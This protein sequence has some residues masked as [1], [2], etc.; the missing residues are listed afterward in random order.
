MRKET[1]KMT[2]TMFQRNSKNLSIMPNNL[3]ISPRQ[4]SG[5]SCE[6]DSSGGFS[7]FWAGFGFGRAARLTSLRIFA[8]K[9]FGSGMSEAG[10]FRWSLA[11][12]LM[13][14]RPHS[15]EPPLFNNRFVPRPA[16]FLLV[17][18]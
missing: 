4:P 2:M 14:L 12:S 13:G 9:P 15:G 17:L 11:E 1:R 8:L 3:P 6:G 10:R 5:L 18:L 16:D 7:A